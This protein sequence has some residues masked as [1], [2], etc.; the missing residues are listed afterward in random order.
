MNIELFMR[1]ETPWSGLA[2]FPNCYITQWRMVACSLV[3]VSVDV[4]YWDAK[5]ENIHFDS[6]DLLYVSLES[7]RHWFIW[8]LAPILQSVCKFHHD[9][10]EVNAFW[11]AMIPRNQMGVKVSKADISQL[12]IDWLWHAA[13]VVDCEERTSWHASDIVKSAVNRASKPSV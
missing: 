10:Y 9:L 6:I 2:E 13:C 7:R 3:F 5:L 8:V 11:T 4:Q 1:A 12:T